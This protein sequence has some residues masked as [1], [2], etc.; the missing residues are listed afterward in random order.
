MWP[1]LGLFEHIN[2]FLIAAY[3]GSSKPTDNAE[4]LSPFIEEYQHLRVSGIPFNGQ[5][6]TIRVK[7]YLCDAPARQ[8]LK[9]IKSRNGYN[10]CERCKVE[11][12]SIERRMIFHDLTAP[13]RTDSKFCGM[14]YPKH[15]M[16]E[17]LW[18]P[19]Y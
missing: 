15:Q 9:S 5:N 18:N 11:G 2:L 8:F 19:L 13:L 4:F 17:S 6:I 16:K 7:G 10:G 3:C 1:I 12:Q 14:D